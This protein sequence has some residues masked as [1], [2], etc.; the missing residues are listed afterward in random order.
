VVAG[1]IV[2]LENAMHVCY[3]GTYKPSYPRNRIVIDGLRAAGV[4]VTEC[5]VQMWG[6]TD[7]RI[8]LA[9]GGW[10]NLRF[11]MKVLR[12]YISLIKQEMVLDDYD[13]MLVGYP[14]IFDMYLARLL[15][16]RRRKPLAFDVLMSIHLIFEERG[17]ASRVPLITHWIYWLER[18]ACK[19]ADNLIID[20]EPQRE[21]FCRKY[22]LTPDKFYLVPLGADNRVYYP[23]DATKPPTEGCV[24]MYYGQFVPLHGVSYIVEAARQLRDHL[25]IQF[26][27][28]GEG[29]TKGAAEKLSERHDLHNVTFTGWVDKTELIQYVSKADICLGIFGDSTQAFHTVPNKIWEGLAMRKAV[30]TG[31]TVAAAEIFQHEKHLYFCPLADSE[32]LATSIL[33]LAEDKALRQALAQQ[34]YEYYLENFTFQKIGKHFARYLAEIVSAHKNL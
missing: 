32:A 22:G 17:L 30:I 13:T 24:V 8:A 20:T 25:G 27:F 19:I 18:G 34:G 12:S 9:S 28:I 5:N 3:F 6:E 23:V 11:W 4:Q 26:I 7:E 1:A 29:V 16:W 2:A 15:T 14:G 21:Y 31:Q 33:R 10:C